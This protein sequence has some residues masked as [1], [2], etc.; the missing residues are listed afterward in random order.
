MD[1]VIGSARHNECLTYHGGK[2]GDQLQH[3]SGDDYSGEVSMQP[4]YVHKKGWIILR[5]KSPEVADKL[6]EAM[7]TAC[8]NANIGY[9][10]DERDQVIEAGVETKKKVNADCSSLV[11][12]CVIAA[13]GKDPGDFTT[14]DEADTLVRTGLFELVNYSS[15]TKVYDGDILVTKSKGHTAIVV[16]SPYKRPS[17]RPVIKKGYK[18]SEQ[19]GEYCAELQQDLNKLGYRDQDGRKLEIDGSCGGRTVSAIKNLQADNDLD[20]D[21]SCGPITWAKIDELLETPQVKRVRTTTSVYLRFGP[22]I[23]YGARKILP[24]GE[25]YIQTAESNGWGYLAEPEAGG[26]VSQK[27]LEPV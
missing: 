27:F 12:A 6:A 13:T 7:R 20:V 4:F 8:N 1:I 17:G 15:K 25:E 23:D 2:P 3:G 9:N 10:Q 22:G 19:G 14:G 5:A 24:E 21:G 16:S 18:D 26:W 11:R